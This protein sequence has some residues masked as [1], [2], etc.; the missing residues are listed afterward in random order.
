MNRVE[1]ALRGWS[2]LA[3]GVY[4]LKP[5]QFTVPPCVVY[6]NMNFFK[7]EVLVMNM[8][9]WI[10]EAR[11]KD[12]SGEKDNNKKKINNK[13]GWSVYDGDAV[14]MFSRWKRPPVSTVKHTRYIIY[15]SSHYEQPTGTLCMLFPLYFFI[16]FFLFLN[17]ISH[18]HLCHNFY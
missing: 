14:G 15:P 4:F 7:I 17:I 11:R 12:D 16:L 6:K 13:R 5:W 1:S 10:E 18:L 8:W 3:R 2:Y 9:R